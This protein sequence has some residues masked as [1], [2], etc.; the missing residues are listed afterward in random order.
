MDEKFLYTIL[1]AIYLAFTI[2]CCLGVF[3]L[4]AVIAFTVGLY[5]CG[6]VFVLIVKAFLVTL[7]VDVFYIV[8]SVFRIA[9]RRGKENQK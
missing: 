6:N 8:F 4:L 1:H 9:L 7:I 5:G 2:I 3:G